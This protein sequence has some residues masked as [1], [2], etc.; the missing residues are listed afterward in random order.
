LYQ[1][2]KE[3]TSCSLRVVSE[4]DSG[5]LVPVYPSFVLVCCCVGVV[6]ELDSGVL[7]LGNS[8]TE[9]NEPIGIG[10]KEPVGM[11]C[12]AKANLSLPSGTLAIW[13]TAGVG[14]SDCLVLGR[15]STSAVEY[16]VVLID[17]RDAILGITD[18]SELGLSSN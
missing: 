13:V 6:F 16:G 18:L 7:E 8:G 12:L 4:F 2:E 10:V 3:A 1:S 11:G 15:L 17:F 9:F 5:I 14:N